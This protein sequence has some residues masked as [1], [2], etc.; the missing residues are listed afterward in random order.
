MTSEEA[1]RPGMPLGRDPGS[2]LVEH[3]D[4]GQK[5][6]GATNVVALLL[7][8]VFFGL[9]VHT[10][11]PH[12]A[13]YRD[14]GE[15]VVLSQTLG[16]A[17]PPGYPLYTLFINAWRYF[18]LGNAAYRVNVFS[19]AAAALAVALLFL[20]L[21]TWTG[22]IA[23]LLS[24]VS[25]GV[26]TVFWE[27]AAVS[28][29]YTLGA[30][31]LVLVLLAMFRW[32]SVPLAAFLFALALGVRMDLL[33]FIPL[34]L[35]WAWTE[36]KF[37]DWKLTT[38]AALI[39]G[40]IFLYM[41]V[42]SLQN[43]L[44]D[45]GNPDNLRAL[46][47]SMSRKSYAS[48]LDLLSLNYKRG[49]NFG[50]NMALYGMHLLKSFSM[51]GVFLAAYGLRKSPLFLVVAFLIAGPVFLFMANM[52]PNPHAVA[53]VEASYL[54]PDIFIAVFI[55]LGLEQL[56]RAPHVY[57][58][59]AAAAFI[60]LAA[61]FPKTLHRVNKRNNFYVQDYLANLFRCAPPRAVVGINKDVQVFSTWVAQLIDHKRPDLSI[62]PVGLSASPWYWEMK[63]R[64]PTALS[65]EISLKSPE[66]W[67][68][69]KAAGRPVVSGHDVE[70]APP[71][72][73]LP[74]VPEL[75]VTRGLYRYGETPDFFS[76]DLIGDHARAYHRR[77]LEA[78]GVK[79][80]SGRKPAVKADAPKAEET[81]A[82]E[83]AK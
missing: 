56:T 71:D 20:L 38:A 35:Y 83:A 52:P 3:L 74:L 47:N 12:V 54:L 59:V 5:R 15:M 79:G 49:E 31:M 80:K 66:G 18:P 36:N 77:G 25:L 62:V 21:R 82:E 50:V 13:P 28:E 19:G 27:L 61:V 7:F 8:A 64:W 16:V 37:S 2:N 57:P 30:L 17:H 32:K 75:C 4:P 45:W 24:A 51:I 68:M 34:M 60:A 67:Q 55:G 65:P 53:I 9:Y 11:A 58:A 73:A 1:R 14:A 23:A 40:S 72:T 44:L 81:K 10:A 33:L 26:S 70:G 48:T 29:M 42:R 6:A 41:M 46:F 69:L 39:G 76:T 78:V 63:K 22:P 43:P